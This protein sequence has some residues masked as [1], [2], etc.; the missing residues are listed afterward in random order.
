M[1]RE[2]KGVKYH[3][4]NAKTFFTTGL[5]A[6]NSIDRIL[7]LTSKEFKNVFIFDL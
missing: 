4:F 3:N 6:K 7:E 2:C 1:Q 5:R